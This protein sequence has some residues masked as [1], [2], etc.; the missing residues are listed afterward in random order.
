MKK[1]KGG[2]GGGGKK[3]FKKQ[4]LGRGFI[5]IGVNYWG[6]GKEKGGGKKGVGGVKIIGQDIQK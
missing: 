1:K 2:G 4:L 6:R 3:G 5:T